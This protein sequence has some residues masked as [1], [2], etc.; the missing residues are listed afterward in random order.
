M[1][2]RLVNPIPRSDAVI[3]VVIPCFNAAET[4]PAAI[5]S[6]CTQDVAGVE[7][8]VVDDGSTDTSL[9][10]ARRFEPLVRVVTGPNRG[11]STARNRGIAGTRGAWIVFLD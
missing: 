9:A 3:C 1:A 6:A 7:I 10:I 2:R 11:V 4:L 5:E 8:I